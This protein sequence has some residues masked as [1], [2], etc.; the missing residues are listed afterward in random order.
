MKTIS[1]IISSADGVRSNP[2]TANQKLEWIANLDGQI[3]ADYLHV[4]DYSVPTKMTDEILIDAPHDEMYVVY[5]LA[6]IDFYMGE[7][8][9]YNAEIARFQTMLDSYTAYVQRNT[10]FP[11]VKIRW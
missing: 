7:M 3:N 1:E 11:A 9:R 4:S 6:Q 2:F 8:T 5:L 10:A